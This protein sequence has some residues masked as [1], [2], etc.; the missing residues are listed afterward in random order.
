MKL[1][2]GVA[3]ALAAIGC[4]SQEAAPAAGISNPAV[5]PD[6]VPGDASVAPPT[7]HEPSVHTGNLP[8]AIAVP[9]AQHDEIEERGS[10]E[11]SLEP[12]DGMG[13]RERVAAEALRAKGLG[14]KPF[15]YVHASWCK[16]CAKLERSMDDPRMR[17]AT[18]G[19]YLVKVDL[20]AF[21]DAEWR[22]FGTKVSP[23]CRRSSR[24]TR[25][26]A[27]RGG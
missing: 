25:P 7:T 18:H 27:R 11:V 3:L 1:T 15:L 8:A 17:D 2:I 21:S 12:I 20:D 13:L 23:S 14:R 4:G 9:I 5:A 26:G 6:L 10:T 19:T 24:S 22:A 16:P